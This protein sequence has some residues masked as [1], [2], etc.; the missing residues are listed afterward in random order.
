M[1]QR[2][3]PAV[4]ERGERG[5]FGVWFPD[6]PGVVTAARTQEEAM[7]KAEKVLA[8]GAEDLAFEG[9]TVPDPTAFD[10]IALPAGC[11]VIALVAVG[12][13]PPDQSE[14]VNVYLPKSLLKRVDR[15]AKEL[16]MSRSSFFGFAVT[17]AIALAE[18]Y[19]AREAWATAGRPKPR[20]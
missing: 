16:G 1:A 9:R 7:A 17:N 11:E 18:R 6:F 4:L 8:Q 15:L 3:Y 12:L 13:D 10:R 19:G 20:R 5:V 14:R 2:F